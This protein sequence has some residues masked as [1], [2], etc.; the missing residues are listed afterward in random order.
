MI[1]DKLDVN[2][3][4]WAHDKQLV[5]KEN[6]QAQMCKVI[7]EVGETAAAVL[8][9]DRERVKDG[10]GDSIVTLSILAAQHGLSL[11]ECWQ[12]AYNEIKNRKGQ[13]VNGTFIKN[14]DNG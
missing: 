14:Q 8:K 4:A 10:I 13:T 3:V 2:T 7:E 11:Q 5:K 6:I 12:A 1:L 9:G